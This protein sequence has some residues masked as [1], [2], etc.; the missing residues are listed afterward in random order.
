MIHEIRTYVPHD[1]KADALRERFLQQV[2]PIFQR[3]G[4][5]LVATYTNPEVPG[6]MAYLT[7]FDDMDTRNA[8]WAAFKDDDEWR[9]VK[10]A[11]ETDGPLLKEQRITLLD[12]IG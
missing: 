7:R 10:S 8:L 1:G 9:T 11:S 2:R 5:D 6:E 12:V 3:L 4:I